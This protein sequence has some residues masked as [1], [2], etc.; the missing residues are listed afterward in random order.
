MRK[1]LFLLALLPSVA[2]AQWIENF[3][4]R[5]T[6]AYCSGTDPA[7]T[8]PV[9]CRDAGA[10]GDNYPVTEN[11]VTFGFATSPS[12]DCRR[13][14]TTSNCSVGLAGNMF[15]SNTNSNSYDFRVD[16]PSA[17]TYQIRVALGDPFNNRARQQVRIYD[18]ST[19]L[20]TIGST[21]TVS[22]GQYLD[23]TSTDAAA[24][25][26]TSAANWASGNQPLE[27]TF[28]TT[29]FHIL[30][31]RG[32]SSSGQTDLAFLGIEEVSSGAEPQ[33]S[34]LNAKINSHL[35]GGLN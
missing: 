18:T 16:L 10:A 32:D 5:D 33:A 11:G 27:L 3:A 34:R 30:V 21:T 6:D 17:G 4:F 1:L 26:H 23:A 22:G 9:R 14:R 25:V 24:V 2:H 20:A 7:N 8:T 31:G 35:N 13:D 29:E 15:Y 12:A 19:L 28:S